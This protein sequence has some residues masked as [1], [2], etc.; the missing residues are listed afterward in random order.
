MDKPLDLPPFPTRVAALRKWV[1]GSF[2][3]YLYILPFFLSFAA[4]GLFPLLYAFRLS[5]TRWHGAG[6]PEFIG[7]SN[8]TFLLQDAIFQTS[9]VNSVVLWLLVVPAQTFLSILVASLLTRP[10]R[11]R[12]AFRTIFLIPYL[13]PLVAIAQ[14]WLILFNQDFGAVN[15]LLGMLH[16]GKV[17]WLNT[18]AWAK[19]TIA[20]LVFWKGFGFSTLIMLAAIQNVPTDI[21]ESANLDGASGAQQFWYITI[22]LMRRTIAFFM[23]IATL[24]ILQMF[25]EPYVLTSGGPYNSSTTAGYMLLQYTRN[26]D[27][28]TGAANSFLLMIIVTIVS[29]V[30]LRLMR[31]NQEV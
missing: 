11:G 15:T 24:G 21:Y 13:V 26:L 10:L 27:L 22:P 4:F 19:P 16:L 23:V 14:V 6:V 9:L 20:L 18:E 1:G 28:G 7:L 12:Q 2:T 8:Y 3:P 29:L 30:M 17:G 25:A 5:F 31:A